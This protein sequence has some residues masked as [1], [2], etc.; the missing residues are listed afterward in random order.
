[1]ALGLGRGASFAIAPTLMVPRAAG[2]LL[3]GISPA[4]VLFDIAADAT[5]A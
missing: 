2:G 3:V 4:A 1:M 5:G